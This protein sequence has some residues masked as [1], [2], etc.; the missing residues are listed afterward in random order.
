MTGVQTCALPIYQNGAPKAWEFEGS[1]V[2]ELYGKPRIPT[3][4]VNPWLDAP[5]KKE[6]ANESDSSSSSG[7]VPVYYIHLIY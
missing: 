1:T 2:E 5:A 3:T 4:T 6:P 7:G